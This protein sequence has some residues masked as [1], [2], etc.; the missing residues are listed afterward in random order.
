M[1]VTL[2]ASG[3]QTAVITT[4][5]TLDDANAA[6]VYELFVDTANMVDGD[7][8]ELRVKAK[9]LTGGTLRGGLIGVFYG[10]QETD[11]VW[12]KS[13]AVSNDLA[14]ADGLVFTLKQTFGTGRN[15]PWKILK[16]A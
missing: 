15:F 4:E 5:H 6:G 13:E 12:K 14:E 7:V 2:F 3:T 16:H 9:V 8:L 1:A 11:D 10:A